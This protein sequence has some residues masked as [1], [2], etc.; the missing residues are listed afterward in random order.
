MVTVTIT[1][2]GSDLIAKYMYE[3]AEKK[4]PSQTRTTPSGVTFKL[5]LPK[6]LQDDVDTWIVYITNLN[7]HTRTAKVTLTW[8]QGNNTLHQR[9][10][11]AIEV[12]GDSNMP[13][14]GNEWLVGK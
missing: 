2:E 14:Y 11:I 12:P 5:G 13:I 6:K 10:P 9:G 1:V 3:C 7:E 4:F 8:V